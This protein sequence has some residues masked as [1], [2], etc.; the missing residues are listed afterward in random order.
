[1]SF[2]KVISIALLF[3]CLFCTEK[4]YAQNDSI[5][6]YKLYIELENAP[7]DSLYLQDY[8]GNR[9]I[10]ISG[11][12]EKKFHW[13][14][15]VPSN[16][17]FDSENMVLLASLYNVSS[18]TKEIIRF[19]G[20]V[21]KDNIIFANIGVEDEN[22]YIY[23]IYHDSNILSNKRFHAVINNKDTIIN[24]NL[25]FLDFKLIIK[26]INSDIAVRSQDPFFSWFLDLDEKK[27]NYDS[28]L[29]SYVE[30]A[31]MHPTSRFLMSSLSR[32]L[33]R[34]K[35][36]NDVK[37]V[38]EN[39]TEKHKN[40]IWAKHIEQFLNERKFPNISLPTVNKNINEKILQDTSKYNLVVFTASWCVPCI[41]EIPLL[42]KIY[43]DLSKDLILTYIS[44]D[45]EKGVSSFKRLV[46][47]KNISWRCLFAYQNINK[48]KQKYFIE[49]I[50]KSILVYP[51][52][53]ME[54]VDVRN[55]E[56]LTKLYNLMKGTEKIN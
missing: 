3:I 39:F 16:I 15:S 10:L 14:I 12:K 38:Y 37:K 47:N 30:L 7:F 20:D 51:N 4:I 8:T 54:V 25:K 1:M 29:N 48:I 50:P 36:K 34:Y 28:I 53:E 11:K 32:M 49:G 33:S 31:K 5:K 6:I 26:D 27:M 35:S 52:Q 13:V 45:D 22:N 41:E 42:Q 2:I 43:K 46:K 55:D 40:T 21:K 17:I 9:N 19:V 24:G 18:N 56:D 44:I 23:G